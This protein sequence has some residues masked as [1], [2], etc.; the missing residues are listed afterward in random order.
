MEH[1]WP[2]AEEAAQDHPQLREQY[3]SLRGKDPREMRDD[4][5]AYGLQM[6]LDGLAGRIVSLA[7]RPTA[8]APDLEAEYAATSEPAD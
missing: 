6:V 8:P 3:A 4:K 5:F 2:A 1:L 7:R